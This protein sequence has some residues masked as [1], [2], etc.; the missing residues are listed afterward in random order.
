MAA[1]PSACYITGLQDDFRGLT[2]DSSLEPP[3]LLLL[4]IVFLV[5]TISLATVR[6]D[7]TTVD[8][9]PHIRFSSFATSMRFFD[10]FANVLEK[11]LIMDCKIH[12]WQKISSEENNSSLMLSSKGLKPIITDAFLSNS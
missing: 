8:F 12:R 5:R 11:C 7:D 10:I 1:R 2:L 6:S 9:D 3:C 4:E